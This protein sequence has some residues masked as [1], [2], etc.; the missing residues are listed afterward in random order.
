MADLYNVEKLLW[1]LRKDKSLAREFTEDPDRVLDRYELD[2]PHRAALK[3]GDFGW[4][5]EAGTNPYLL[6][7]FALQVGVDRADYYAAVRG[8]EVS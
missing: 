8:E 7:F 5:L 4:L 6:Y 1:Q 3:D 2:A